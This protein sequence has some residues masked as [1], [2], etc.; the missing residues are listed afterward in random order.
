[1]QPI[2]VIKHNLPGAILSVC[3]AGNRIHHY[4][5]GYADI[6]TKESLSDKPIF[7]IGK[8]T[9]FFTAAIILKRLEEGVVDLDAPWPC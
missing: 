3:K 4:C 2:N 1:M 9:R 8:I 6:K 7:P 5:S